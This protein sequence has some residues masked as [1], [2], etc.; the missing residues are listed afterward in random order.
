MKHALRIVV[1]LVVVIPVTGQPWIAH[2]GALLCAAVASGFMW[3][4]TEPAPRTLVSSV[5]CGALVLGATGF[6]AGFFGP[7]ILAPD[8]NQGPLLGLF[9]TGPGGTMIGAVGGFL[10]WSRWR[11]ATRVAPDPTQS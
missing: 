3:S 4:R 5:L 6:A 11:R 1:V 10:Y 7:M 8:A 9:I 2:A